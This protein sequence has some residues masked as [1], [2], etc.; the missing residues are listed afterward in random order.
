MLSVDCAD[1]RPH[2]LPHQAAICI[3]AVPGS[4]HWNLDG[5]GVPSCKY[6]QDRDARNREMELVLSFWVRGRLLTRSASQ[7]LKTCTGEYLTDRGHFESRSELLTSLSVEFQ[8]LD[9]AHIL[10]LVTILISFSTPHCRRLIVSQI[11]RFRHGCTDRCVRGGVGHHE[12]NYASRK[13]GTKVD[14]LEI[15]APSGG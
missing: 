1:I 3:A 7:I 6:A 11:P 15:G 2:W 10:H 13:D 5:H 8:A 4:P 9:L 14:R 12:L